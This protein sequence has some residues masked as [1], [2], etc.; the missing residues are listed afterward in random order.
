MGP[1]EP[2]VYHLP[3]LNKSCRAILEASEDELEE[4]VM[5][6]TYKVLC[7]PHC[8]NRSYFMTS[9]LSMYL[10]TKETPT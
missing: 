1:P 4:E 6:H 3:C 10:T 5:K 2:E 9:D 8:L 7:C